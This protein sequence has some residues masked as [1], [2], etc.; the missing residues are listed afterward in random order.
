M[1]FRSI[2]LVTGLVVTVSLVIG[3]GAG[4]EGE[5]SKTPSAK[6]ETATP[7]SSG[8]DH[9]TQIRESFEAA[10]TKEL[11][12]F[13]AFWNE[14]KA[15]PEKHLFKDD[16]LGEWTVVFAKVNERFS[17]EIRENK[18]S[19]VTPYTGIVKLQAD[20]CV[21]TG[22]TRSRCLDSVCK[23]PKKTRFTFKYGYQ[24]NRWILTDAPPDYL[25]YKM[26]Q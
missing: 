15:H 21:K 11:R 12:S 8:Q 18:D 10:I 5:K 7:A 20:T 14:I 4:T 9:E 22:N 24:D 19:L 25:E 23:G 17:C 26:K 3:C 1:N 13:Q 2:V 16:L 6:S